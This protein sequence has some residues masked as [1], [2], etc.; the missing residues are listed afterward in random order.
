[1]ER[2]SDK[3]SPRLD[4]QMAHEVESLTNGLAAEESR[5]REDRT[6]E[7][8]TEEEIRFEPADRTL[9]QD[10]GIGIPDTDADA[11]SDLARH[12]A[13]ADWP[14]RGDQLYEAARVERAPQQI[15]DS[16]R[17]LPAEATFGNV[18]EVWASLGGATEDT[19]THG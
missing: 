4:D 3:H 5:A 8:S 6:L 7:G 12:L 9:P 17:R 14:A 19:H 10:R 13:A 1:M 18:Q 16:L 15:L 2:E 11:R